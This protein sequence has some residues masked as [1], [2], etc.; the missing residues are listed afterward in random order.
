MGAAEATWAASAEATWEASLEATWEAFAEI[1]SQA[2]AEIT[3]AEDIVSAAAITAMAMALIA[4]TTAHSTG[5]TP[6]PTERQADSE[7]AG[8]R[9]SLPQRAHL[10]NWRTVERRL[11]RVSPNYE[12]SGSNRRRDGAAAGFPGTELE[13]NVLNLNLMAAPR[14]APII[15]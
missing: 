15:W 7:V 9:L 14:A 4:R 6:A 2:F 8:A 1:T 10:E 13:F 3:L 5:R 11:C 12:S